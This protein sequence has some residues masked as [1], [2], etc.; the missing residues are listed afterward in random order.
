MDDKNSGNKLDI[1]KRVEDNQPSI[2]KPEDTQK[3]STQLK[4]FIR[5][6][7]MTVL[8]VYFVITFIIQPT[9]VDGESMQP[10]LNNQD[11]LLIEKV[12]PRFMDYQRNDIIVFPDQRVD[13]KFYIKRIIGLPGETVNIKNGHVYINDHQLEELLEL[14]LITEMG[15]TIFP[16]TLPK[17]TYF[18]LGDNRNHSKDSRYTDIGMIHKRVILGKAFIRL[19]PFQR[20]GSLN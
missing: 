13:K 4:L 10:T 8:A 9:T 14:E 17:D 3:L 20:I 18:V 15:S 1:E 6:L 16:V 11:Q 7:F 2:N 5:D 19:Y 12:S